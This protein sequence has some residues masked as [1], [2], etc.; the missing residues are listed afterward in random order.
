MR[1]GAKDPGRKNNFWIVEAVACYMES[2]A[3]HRLLDDEPY[4]AYWT[5]GGENE[6]RVPAAR[7][8]LLDDQFYVPLRELSTSGMRDLQ[9]DGRLPMIYSQIS[10]QVLFIMHADGGR[11]RQPLMNYL[12]AVYT[13][14]CRS[15][16]AG[17][18]DRREIRRTRS[19]V[20]RVH[21]IAVRSLVARRYHPHD[22]RLTFGCGSILFL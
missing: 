13:E 5:A 17:E 1:S 20:S 22:G 2:L 16:D 9:H 3:E 21:E 18:T 15:G 19:A 4:G 10:G 8:R 14:H 6:G 11:Y 12:I 7:K